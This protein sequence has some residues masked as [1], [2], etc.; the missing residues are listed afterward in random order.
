MFVIPTDTCFWL[1]C[2]V[3]DLNWY[4]NIYKIKW[5]NFDKPISIFVENFEYLEKYT[6]L[7]KDNISFLKYYKKPFTVVINLV[8]ITDKE[9][10]Q[11]ISKLP[12]IEIYNKI[13]FRVAHTKLQ[14]NLIYKNGLFFLTSLNKSKE[15]EIINIKDIS[16]ELEEDLLKY[17]VQILDKNIVSK[18]KFS[19]IIEFKNNEIIFLRK[20]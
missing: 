17:N 6:K 8:D 1:W 7:T 15:P 14:K 18:Q 13:A 3:N 20:Y 11:N 9:L 19:D 16:Q 4:R 5:R 10:L 2:F 12:N